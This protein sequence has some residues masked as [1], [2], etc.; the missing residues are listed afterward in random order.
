MPSQDLGLS[1]TESGLRRILQDCRT[2]GTPCSVV[3]DQ[4]FLNVMFYKTSSQGHIFHHFIARTA[5][6]TKKRGNNFGTFQLQILRMEAGG[7]GGY[8]FIVLV[9]VFNRR[10]IK[11][12]KV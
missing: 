9:K 6:V 2:F 1:R 11:L 3:V 5:I 8:L 7:R 4:Q 10:R 12:R